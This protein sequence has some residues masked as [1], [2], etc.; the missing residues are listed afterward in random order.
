MNARMAALCLQVV[1][2]S[3]T[4]AYGDEPLSC[5]EHDVYH[6]LDFCVGNREVVDTEG[7]LQGHNRIEKIR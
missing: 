3:T 7:A 2:S 4:N 1:I 6:Q 5:S